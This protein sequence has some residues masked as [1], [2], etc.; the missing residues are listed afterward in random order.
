M[1]SIFKEV[2]L[3]KLVTKGASGKEEKSVEEVLGD[4]EFIGIYFSAHWCP[5]CRGFTPVLAESYKKMDAAGAKIKFVFSS[6]DRTPE[7]FEGYYG[8][9]PWDAVPYDQAGRTASQKLSGKFGVRG[10]PFLV[11]VNKDGKEVTK[12]GRAVIMEHKDDPSGVVA[13]LKAM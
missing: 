11:F 9:M 12:D 5:P 3:E 7:E 8:D 6:S 2:G 1:A 10:I 13:A 4:A